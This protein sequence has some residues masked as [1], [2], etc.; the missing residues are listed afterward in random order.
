[1]TIHLTNLKYREYEHTHY[2]LSAALSFFKDQLQSNQIISS[3]VKNP[4]HNFFEKLNCS[5]E[6]AV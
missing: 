5:E 2:F 4:I 3:S 6:T 1:M